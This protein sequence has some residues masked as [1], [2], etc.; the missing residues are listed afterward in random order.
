MANGIAV[1]FIT[2]TTRQPLR[3][4]IEK[5]RKIG[6]ATTA[7][8]VFMPALAAQRY[9]RQRNLTPYLLVHP[10]VVEDL[11]PLSQG[12]IGAVVV[13]DAADGF[14]Y[15]SLNCAYRLL[16]SGA[17]FL[18]LAGNRSFRDADGELSLD[19]GPFVAALQYATGRSA[20]LLGKP[21]AAYFREALAS[22]GGAA[23]EVA[24][25]GDDVEADVAGGMAVG[26]AGILVQTG[27]Y[28]TGDEMKIEPP[29]TAVVADLSEAVTWVLA[30]NR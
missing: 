29:P 11:A 18:A 6:V 20:I 7:D 5:L 14:T 21:S 28:E 15:A 23:G 13:G 4:L 8:D 16:N 19:A 10:N 2:N 22:L 27:K 17:E 25:I 24:M 3:E 9:M 26:L 1:R 30:Q 12:K